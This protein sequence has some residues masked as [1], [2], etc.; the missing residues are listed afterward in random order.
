MNLVKATVHGD[1]LVVAVDLVVG[2][3]TDL[4]PL[5][6]ATLDAVL[7]CVQTWFRTVGELLNGEEPTA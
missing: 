7:G 4:R 2:E 3:E 1:R 6:T 5:L